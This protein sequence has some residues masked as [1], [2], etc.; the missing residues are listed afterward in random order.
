MGFECREFLVEAARKAGIDG[1]AEF[2]EDPNNGLQEV[3]SSKPIYFKSI[4]F[5]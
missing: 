2:L 3:F 5:H 4:S 1:A